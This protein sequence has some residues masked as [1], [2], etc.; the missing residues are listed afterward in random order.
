MP[1]VRVLRNQKLEFFKDDNRVTPHSIVHVDE[2]GLLVASHMRIGG[3]FHVNGIIE[4]ESFS[5][6]LPQHTHDVSDVLGA[7]GNQLTFSSIAVYNSDGLQVPNSPYLALSP[8]DSIILKASG[9]ISFVMESNGAVTIDDTH[10]H[11]PDEISGFDAW[12]ESNAVVVAAYNLRHS[13]SN[14]AL[15]DTYSQT[16]TNLSDAVNKKHDRTHGLTSSDHTISGL[17]T[18][19]VLKATSSTTFGFGAIQASEIPNLDWAKI[20]TGKPTSVSG[21]GITDSY[22]KSD[23][24]TSGH[25]LVHWDNL[26]NVPELNVGP[27]TH[28][29]SEVT[30]LQDALDG[31][32]PID[33]DLTDIAAI[34]PL[35]GHFLRRAVSGWTSGTILAADIPGLDWTKIVSNK[36][37]TLLGYGITDAYTKIESDSLFASIDHEHGTTSIGTYSIGDVKFVTYATPEQGWLECDGSAISRIE[38]SELFEKIGTTYGEGDGITTFNLPDF[39]GEFIRGWDHGK[40]TDPGR[41]LG[42]YQADDF[43]A[44]KHQETAGQNVGSGYHGWNIGPAQDLLTLFQFTTETGGTET[45]PRNI[46]LMVVIKA[47][48]GFDPAVQNSN[49]DTVDGFH[50]T[51]FYLKGQL[52]FDSAKIGDIKFIPHTNIPTGWMECDGRE[53]SRTIFSDLFTVIGTT[54][55]SG[56][57]TY[58]F[59]LPDLRGEFIRGW[60]HGKGIDLDRQLGSWQADEFKAHYHSTTFYSSISAGWGSGGRLSHGQDESGVYTKNTNNTG[61]TETRPRNVAFM[62][63]IKVQHTTYNPETEGANA[64]TLD[65]YHANAFLPETGSNANGTWRKWADGTLECWGIKNLG[66]ISIS[67]VYGSLYRSL[68]HQIT[69]PIT[70]SSL[71]HSQVD[72]ISSSSNNCF[73]SSTENDS[74]THFKKFFISSTMGYA[75]ISVVVSFHAIG[76]WY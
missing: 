36:P 74:I 6:Q 14:K 45:R 63:I 30:G 18:G 23:L 51:D 4:A 12:V 28:L 69:W 58:T 13:H 40:G 34:S 55:G 20:T 27:H 25:A 73:V 37:T 38:Y 5:G 71:Y 1:N 76:R 68:L 47:K 39:R 32:Q 15:L 10:Y 59:N 70:F 66:T 26:T 31:K 67:E 9:N 7:A 2:N 53:L 48:D 49:A 54:F 35:E 29:I 19:H 75:N 41:A 50:A 24:Q 57:G 8:T 56:D 3:N 11:S 33:Q 65:G 60:D 16:E 62:F 42:S 52:P 21:Y 61:G 44:H 43:K 72:I 46:A 17:T 22:T 64:D